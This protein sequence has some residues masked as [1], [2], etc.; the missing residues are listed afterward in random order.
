MPSNIGTFTFDRPETIDDA[1]FSRIVFIRPLETAVQPIIDHNVELISTVRHLRPWYRGE[2]DGMEPEL[3]SSLLDPDANHAC[4]MLK[5]FIAIV[6]RYNPGEFPAHCCKMR[7]LE[8]TTRYL[9][10]ELEKCFDSPAFTNALTQ[11]GH[12]EFAWSA[13]NA[14]MYS[15][16]D[17][18]TRLDTRLE[19]LI[20]SFAD[21][22]EA[23]RHRERERD[24]EIAFSALPPATVKDVQD[25]ADRIGDQ[26]AATGAETVRAVRRAKREVIKDAHTARK[27]EADRRL[28]KGE[29]GRQI[30]AVRNLVREARANGKRTTILQAC[31]KAWSKAKGGYPSAIALYQYCHDHAKDF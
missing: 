14:S 27:S 21:I 10:H 31:R 26:V 1:T 16:V 12:L 6:K 28:P 18:M 9:I 5:A 3:L 2:H 20:R 23:C 15:F 4:E 25:A 8:F 17:W 24:S 22:A 29:R 7:E 13:P 30:A 19:C 11:L